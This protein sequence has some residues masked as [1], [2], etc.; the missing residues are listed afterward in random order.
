MTEQ[1]DAKPAVGSTAAD[2][3]GRQMAERDAA[4]AH[5]LKTRDPEREERVTREQEQFLRLLKTL[6]F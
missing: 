5:R 2:D 1:S 3:A 6:T 4:L